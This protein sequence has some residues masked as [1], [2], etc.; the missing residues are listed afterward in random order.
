M[1]CGLSKAHSAPEVLVYRRN[2]RTTFHSRLLI[3]ERYQQGWKQAHIG[4]FMVEGVVVVRIRRLPAE[5]ALCS[6]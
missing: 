1:G 6:G 2:A 4:L 5:T 3:I